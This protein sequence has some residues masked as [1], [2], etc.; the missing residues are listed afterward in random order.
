MIDARSIGEK[1]I[2]SLLHEDYQRMMS[3]K[4]AIN[5]SLSIQSNGI[6]YLNL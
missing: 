3:K 4:Y 1:L 6:V 5:L 2:A